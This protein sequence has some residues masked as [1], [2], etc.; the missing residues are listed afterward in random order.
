MFIDSHAHLF[1]KD[2]EPD[3]ADVLARAKAAGVTDVVNPGTDLETSRQSLA[4]AAAHPM[5]HP[6]VGFHPHDAAKADDAALAEIE[7]LSHTP[8]VVAIGE[9]GLDYHYNFSPPDVQRAVFAAQILI[10]CDRDLPIIIHSRE[11]EADTFK[12]VGDIV[13]DHPGWRNTPGRPTRGVF[14]CFPGDAAM[15]RTVIGW[16][17]YVSI[18]GPVTFPGKPDRPNVMAAVAAEIPLEDMLLETDSPY[19]TPTPF[20]GKRNEPSHIPLI[21]RKIAELRGVPVETVGEATSAATRN[22]FRLSQ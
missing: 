18:P 2:Y 4:L 10:A 11:A 6:A 3:L 14:H 21:A 9:I 13:R 8:G 17:F 5:I 20:R 22:L 19:L 16:G 15:A 12:I 7:S 1:F